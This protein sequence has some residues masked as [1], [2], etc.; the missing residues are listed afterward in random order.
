MYLV[1]I[2]HW[3][4]SSLLWLPNKYNVTFNIVNKDLNSLLLMF[5]NLRIEF[6]NE[7][8]LITYFNG[9]KSIYFTGTDKSRPITFDF[10]GG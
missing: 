5:P 3:Y 2:N 1:L 9:N 4:T 10:I 7:K 6:K 8:K